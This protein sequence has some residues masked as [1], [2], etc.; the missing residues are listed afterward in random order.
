MHKRSTMLTRSPW[1]IGI[2]AS[3]HIS[4]EPHTAPFIH[5]VGRIKNLMSDGKLTVLR[6]VFTKVKQNSVFRTIVNWDELEH[7]IFNDNGNEVSE[8]DFKDKVRLIF[9]AIG[10]RHGAFFY[11]GERLGMDQSWAKKLRIP[12][13]QPDKVSLKTKV[14]EDGYG[15]ILLP[16]NNRYDSETCQRYQDSLCSLG[17]ATLKGLIID[18]RLHQ[19]G[20]VNPLFA[21]LN[22][23][24]GARYFGSN[25]NLDGKVFQKWSTYNGAYGRNRVYN[26]CE[27][28]NTLK[29]VVLT[30]QITASAGEMMAV[31]L[32]G[33]SKTLFI[34]EPTCGLT[35]MNA[36]FT[37]GNNTLAVAASIIADRKGNIYR[38][39]VLPDLTIIEGDNFRD[40]SRDTK[41]AAALKWMKER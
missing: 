14:L 15:Y 12:E 36:I 26:R 6:E 27:A 35:T 30:S 16:S 33:R 28:N 3:D 1:H 31:A 4:A 19:G 9:T 40:L 7:K 24:Y 11:N 25:M 17:L 13:N 37:L 38:D 5:E 18:L 21:G 8:A 23:L 10:D 2:A 34:G 22:Q 20:S 29:I 41:V 39:S 32:K